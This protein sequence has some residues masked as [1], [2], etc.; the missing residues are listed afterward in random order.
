MVMT[1]I[2]Y[3]YIISSVFRV[4]VFCVKLTYNSEFTVE[5]DMPVAE[6]VEWPS[7]DMRAFLL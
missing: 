5:P 3:N 2:K 4:T 7:V 1:I 6:Y